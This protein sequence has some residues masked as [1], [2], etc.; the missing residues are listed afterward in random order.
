G[1]LLLPQVGGVARGASLAGIALSLILGIIGFFV[2]PVIGLPIGATLGIYIVEY[3]REES[4]KK[5]AWDTT[6]GVLL[7]FGIGVA[8]ELGSGFLMMGLWLIWVII[9]LTTAGGAA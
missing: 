6:K 2:I 8:V 9:N 4:D 1:S 7:G 3:I 5:K